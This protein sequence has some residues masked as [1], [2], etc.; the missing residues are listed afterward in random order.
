MIYLLFFLAS[1]FVAFVFKQFIKQDAG[2][3]L[4][5]AII[6][7]PT[8]LV[9]IQNNNISEFTGFGLSAKFSDE[10]SKSVSD[11]KVSIPDLTKLTASSDLSDAELNAYFEGCSDFFVLK[12][13]IVPKDQAKLDLFI[14]RAA[15]AIKSSITCGKLTGVVVVDDRG[16][17]LGSYDDSFYLEALSIWSMSENDQPISSSQLSRKIRFFT[18]FGASMKFP[19]LRIRPGEGFVAA[20]NEDQTLQ[21]AFAKF[22]ETGADFLVVTD[23]L[24]TFKGILKYR[25]VVD[26]FLSVLVDV[27]SSK[28]EAAKQ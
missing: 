10:A 18:M 16:K 19:D 2:D 14:A 5:A 27:Q 12:P 26:S 17:Y 28:S 11:L 7:L 3:T 4:L 8:L 24:G 1:L 9:W 23:E 20:I 22:Q 25:D 15:W 13:S 21:Q 6:F